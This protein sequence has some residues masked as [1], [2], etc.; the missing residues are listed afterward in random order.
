MRVQYCFMRVPYSWNPT[1]SSLAGMAGDAVGRCAP[2]TLKNGSARSP[3]IH[4]SRGLRVPLWTV[5]SQDRFI[6]TIA[7]LPMLSTFEFWYRWLLTASV[8]FVAFGIFVAFFPESVVL[9]P[10]NSALAQAVSDGALSEETSRTKAFM[11]G[12]LGGTIAGFYVLQSFIIWRPFRNKEQWSWWAVSLATLV[13]FAVD[14]VLSVHHGA[15]FNVLMINL[16][17]LIVIGIPLLTTFSDF[18]SESADRKTA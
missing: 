3:G 2:Q 1:G 9:D 18:H 6:Q 13:W 11:M 5:R 4:F 12:P 7:A 14:S 10:W 15:S 8:A 16:P 17:A